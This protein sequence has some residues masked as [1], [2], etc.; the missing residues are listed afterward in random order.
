MNEK[1]RRDRVFGV[2]DIHQTAV[3]ALSPGTRAMDGLYQLLNT[4]N[5][6]FYVV[7]TSSTAPAVQTVTL[8]IVYIG[9]FPRQVLLRA[10]NIYEERSV[11]LDAEDMLSWL[12]Y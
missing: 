10:T 3:W 12:L 11:G 7:N 5:A 2:L 6:G 8:F 9:I 4:R 1:G